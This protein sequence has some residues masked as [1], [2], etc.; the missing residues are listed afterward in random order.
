MAVVPGG[1]A[2]TA[3]GVVVPAVAATAVVAIAPAVAAMAVAAVAAAVT[4]HC[5]VQ[6]FQAVESF[7]DFLLG[8]TK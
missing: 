1:A 7:A 5:K 4:K 8:F 3:V 2:V 6:R